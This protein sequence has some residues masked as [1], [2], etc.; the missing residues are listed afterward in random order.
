MELGFST[1]PKKTCDLIINSGNHY[2]IAVKNNQPKLYQQIQVNTQSA[3]PLTTHTSIE[4]KHGRLTKRRISVFDDLTGITNQWIGLKT[5]IKVERTGQR[6]RQ[7]YVMVAYYISSLV[8]DA[9]IFA[10]G[11]RGHWGIENRLHWSKDVV[12]KEDRSSI[13]AAHAPANM[14]IIRSIVINLLRSNGFS[15]VTIAQRLISNNIP[16]LLA[17][18][19]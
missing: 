16:T 1:L 8:A 12:F 15:S 3:V 5:L 19:Q 7:A 2:A 14:S 9:E 11:I 18:L 6:G 13:K 10:Q 17:L 4:K